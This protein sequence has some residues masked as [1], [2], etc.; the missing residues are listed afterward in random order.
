MLNKKVGSFLSHP[1]WQGA[2]VLVALMGVFVTLIF[3]CNPTP[4]LEKKAEPRRLK[5]N[6]AIDKPKSFLTKSNKNRQYRE[7]DLVKTIPFRASII[8]PSNIPVF[9]VYDEKTKKYKLSKNVS[10]GDFIIFEIHSFANNAPLQN[11]RHQLGYIHN[12]IF[13]ADSSTNITAIVSAT[14]VPTVNGS[15][16]LFFND[17]V[18]LQYAGYKWFTRKVNLKKFT[19]KELPNKQHASWVYQ[20]GVTL[21][22]LPANYLSS[23]II[24]FKVVSSND[25]TQ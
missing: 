19:R 4:Q 24:R 10:I 9:S 5:Q 11:L 25:E 12:K 6:K 16:S 23:F 15:V 18:K 20:G 8:S 3:S 14:G 17:T 7:F 21:G 13:T 1:G 22:D 2:G